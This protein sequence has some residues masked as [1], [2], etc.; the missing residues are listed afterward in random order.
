M[1][2]PEILVVKDY[3]PYHNGT[4]CAPC[5][6]GHTPGALCTLI[7]AYSS[8]KAEVTPELPQDNYEDREIRLKIEVQLTVVYLRQPLLRQ[9]HPAYPLAKKKT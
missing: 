2:G 3:L 9:G 7:H 4:S 5:A 1:S 6:V 8:L